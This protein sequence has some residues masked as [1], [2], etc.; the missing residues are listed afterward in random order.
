MDL[1]PTEGLPGLD[2]R[3]INVDLPADEIFEEETAGVSEHPGSLRNLPPDHAIGHTFV[4]RTGVI[5]PD[6]STIAGR[7]L[8]AAAVR[9]VTKR[10]NGKADLILSNS[11]KPAAEYDNP[12]LIPAMFPTLFPLGTG[13]LEDRGRTIPI[14]L[15]VHADYLLDTTDRTIRNHYSFVFLFLNIWLRR[16]AHLHIHLVVSRMNIEKAADCIRDV[17]NESLMRLSH[18]LQGESMPREFSSEDRHA[19]ELLKIVNSVST[20]VPGSSASKLKMRNT[21]LAYS[22]Y[23]ASPRCISPSTPAL[24][25]PLF[26]RSC[27]AIHL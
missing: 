16:L 24:S 13:G 9:N 8:H 23:L 25:I 12:T 21:V 2:D 18:H 6:G 26:S 11:A 20:N 15:R 1:Y 19:F 7:E 27:T 4:E 14:S 22:A 5:D 10:L 17:T 3:I